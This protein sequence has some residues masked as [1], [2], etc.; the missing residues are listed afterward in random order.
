MRRRKR[1]EHEAA[2]VT[3]FVDV[4]ASAMFSHDDIVTRGAAVLALTRILSAH[5]PI[6][7]YV[8]LASTGGSGT[9]GAFAVRINSTP[10]DL[11]HASFALMG[12]S[13]LRRIGFVTLEGINR[14][15]PFPPLQGYTLSDIAQEMLTLGTSFIA[16]PGVVS[17]VTR[18]PE[19][20]ITERIR[21]VAPEIIG[22]EAR[23]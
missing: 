22:E 21:E 11:A 15:H 19:R 7:L 5:R 23:E 9:T 2:P 10:L 18:E 20:W 16:I 6:E 1:A 8:A 13:F 3:I 17:S 12:V 4:F 14:S